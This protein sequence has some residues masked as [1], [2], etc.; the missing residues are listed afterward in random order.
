M[1]EAAGMGLA[2]RVEIQP[3]PRLDAE[4]EQ[5]CF[6]LAQEA[7]SNVI[8][9]AGATTVRVSLARQAETVVLEIQDDGRGFS[10]GF[11]MGLGLVGARERAARLSGTLEVDSSPGSGTRL[12]AVLPWRETA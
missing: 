11:G 12:R 6:R 2:T 8:H 5:T 9:H 7:L 10:P 1:R 3:L 4:L